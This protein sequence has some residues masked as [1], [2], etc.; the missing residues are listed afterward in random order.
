MYITPFLTINVIAI[1]KAVNSSDNS[2]QFFLTK[3]VI[4]HVNVW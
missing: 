1:A 4:L 2:H 3:D